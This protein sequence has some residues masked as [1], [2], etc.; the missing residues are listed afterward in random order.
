MNTRPDSFRASCSLV[1]DAECHVTKVKPMSNMKASQV[2]S[3]TLPYFLFVV[4]SLKF[5][6][7]FPKFA[8]W[9][10]RSSLYE[11]ESDAIP[12]D[13]IADLGKRFA[14]L[15]LQFFLDFRESFRVNQNLL[16]PVEDLCDCEFERLVVSVKLLEKCPDDAEFLSFL[17]F[18][19]PSPFSADVLVFGHMEDS[20]IFWGCHHSHSC[21][22]GRGL[23]QKRE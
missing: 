21:T 1:H 20:A 3:T 16:G 9:S 12:E 8:P 19:Q 2:R 10:E 7:V 4:F 17:V 22:R 13:V 15:F 5:V 14:G 23:G 11:S 6:V 18:K